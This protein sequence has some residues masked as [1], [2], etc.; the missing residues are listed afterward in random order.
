MPRSCLFTT[1]FR[2]LCDPYV[3]RQIASCLNLDR[4]M[5]LMPMISSLARSLSMAA[6][7]LHSSAFNAEREPLSLP[8]PPSLPPSPTTHWMSK[9]VPRTRQEEVLVIALCNTPV[10]RLASEWPRSK[11]IQLGPQFLVGPGMH[12]FAWPIPFIKSA[13]TRATIYGRVSRVHKHLKTH[14]K[15]APNG[16]HSFSGSPS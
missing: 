1:N 4:L 14:Q 3:T 16:P 6:A 15:Q 8:F 13:S 5:L 2:V 10:L 11:G 9:P 7:L 12:P